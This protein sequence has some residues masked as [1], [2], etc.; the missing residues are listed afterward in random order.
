MIKAIGDAN[1]VIH[2]RGYKYAQGRDALDL[3]IK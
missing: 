3:L 1:D 2:T